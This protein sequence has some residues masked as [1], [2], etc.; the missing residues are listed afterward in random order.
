MSGLLDLGEI[1]MFQKERL[2][3]ILSNMGYGSRKVVKNYIKDGLVK[4]NQAII[5]D[6]GYKVNPY[7]ES[8]FFKG[9]EILYR[10]YIY[11]MMNKP[12]GLVSSTEDPLTKTV[13]DLLDEDYLI[14]KP[15]P[16]G[17]LDKDTEGLMLISND[18]KLAHELLSPKKGVNKRYYA[19]INGYVEKEHIKV[20][21][22]G[23]ILDDGYKTL[24]AELEIVESDLFSKI[25]LT[26]QEGKYH[27]VK[28]MFESLSMKVVF[29]KRVSMGE[30][31]LDSALQL[32]EYREITDEELK[33]LKRR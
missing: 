24:P 22:Q 23:I 13:I 17:R 29:L 4:V 6:N 5:L 20:F 8:I 28:R 31:I 2:D 33:L 15:F 30:L 12:Q 14:Y 32:G 27:Q 10:K 21:S 11:I 9:E 7:E 16:V 19:E 26:I 3:K 1:E 25:Y 18:G